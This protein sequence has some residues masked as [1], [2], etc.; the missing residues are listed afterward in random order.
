[1][2]AELMDSMSIDVGAEK[3]QLSKA[4]NAIAGTNPHKLLPFVNS[5]HGKE[6]IS[7]LLALANSPDNE[8]S[9]SATRLRD[10]VN[11]VVSKTS[12]EEIE[13]F[14]AVTVDNICESVQVPTSEHMS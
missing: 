4:L 7:K 1:M 2:L 5:D 14:T 6:L 12:D 10:V 9:S 11:S 3:P 8:I 13:R